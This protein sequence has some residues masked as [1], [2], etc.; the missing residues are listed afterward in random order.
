MFQE[1]DLLGSDAMCLLDFYQTTQ[2]YHH[3]NH[4]FNLKSE[5]K[6]SVQFI[7]RI[8]QAKCVLSVV[9]IKVMEENGIA[10]SF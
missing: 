6:I 8:A 2:H 9:Y 1:H 7:L 10:K 3:E 4:R 5:I